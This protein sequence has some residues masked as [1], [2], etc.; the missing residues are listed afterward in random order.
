MRLIRLIEAHFWAFLLFA[1]VCG[2]VLPLPAERML[3]WLKPELMVSLFLVFLKIDILKILESIRNLRRMSYLLSIFLVLSPLVVYFLVRPIQA[4]WALALALLMAVPSG[5]TAPVLT[6]IVKGNTE[7]ST[8]LTILTALLAPFTLPLVFY[9]VARGSV[10][11]DSWDLFWEAALLILVPMALATLVRPLFPR[12]IRKAMPAF[13]SINIVM[14]FLIVATSF[15]SQRASLLADP[16]SLLLDLLLMFLVFVVLHCVGF[17]LSWGN[18]P[19]DRIAI[20]ISHTYMN[21]GL[22]IVLAAKFF[23]PAILILMVL[24]EIPWSTMLVGLHWVIRKTRLFYPGS[25]SVSRG[26]G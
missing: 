25:T 5:V 13:T 3:P 1:M 8:S 9:F 10:Q 24:S 11:L 23:S 12:L 20:T 17:L 16:L 2:L 4:E 18:S 19:E 7:L 15:G 22:A 14:M 6:D 26:N 21:N